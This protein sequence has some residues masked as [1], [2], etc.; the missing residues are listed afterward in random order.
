MMKKSTVD[1]IRQRFDADVER[2]SKLEEGQSATMDSPR[3]M[4]LIAEAAAACTPGAKRVLDV[5]CGAGNYTLR[6]LKELPEIEAVLVDL[7]RPMLERAQQRFR[8]ASGREAGA[9]QG[10]VREIELGEGKFDVI[11]AASV[12]HHLREEAEWRSVF[13]K[14]HRAL[15]P[16]GSVWIFDLVESSLPGVERV[17]RRRYGEYLV[18]LRDAAY[19][20]AVFAYIEKED[21]PR[22]V[23][24][25]LRLLSE[26]GFGD[27]ADVLHKNT[28][29]AAFGA[30]KG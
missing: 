24:W 16:G 13:G 4:G 21:T 28:N 1:E 18:N 7:S 27:A 11:L 14:F 12:L 22:P 5:G 10:D 23:T 15:R 2:F 8:Q 30:V 9:V 20:D 19:R 25:Q 26:A 29:F 6:L 3:A 17:M